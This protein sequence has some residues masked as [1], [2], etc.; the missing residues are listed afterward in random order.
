M[1]YRSIFSLLL[2]LLFDYTVCDSA[3]ADIARFRTRAEQLLESSYSIRTPEELNDR[4]KAFHGFVRDHYQDLKHSDMIR[5]LLGQ[6]FIMHEYVKYHTKGAPVTDI[7]KKYRE[8]V[9]AGVGSCFKI[10]KPY[11]PE[12]EIL[13]DCVSLYYNRS[14]VTLAS[15]IIANFRDVAYCPGVEK[16][17]FSFPDELAVVDAN[18]KMERKLGEFRGDRVIA[19][20]SNDCPVSMVE[21]ISKVRELADRKKDVPVIVAPLQKLSGSHLA[22][23]R[24]LSSGNIFFINDEKWRKDNLPKNIKLPLFIRIGDALD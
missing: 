8:A 10:L 4:K 23:S 21:T 20:V 13:N 3:R 5:R 15:L 18:G 17:K 14:M 1:P 12:H 7:R 2:L 19:F 22:M 16:E 24:M 9:L 11:I 6:Y